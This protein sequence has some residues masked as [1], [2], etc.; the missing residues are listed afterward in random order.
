MYSPLR[1]DRDQCVTFDRQKAGQRRKHW[2]LSIHIF[3]CDLEL[4]LLRLH[5]TIPVLHAACLIY[6]SDLTGCPT[7]KDLLNNDKLGRPADASRTVSRGCIL[8]LELQSFGQHSHLLVT[9][10]VMS[11]LNQASLQHQTAMI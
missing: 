8:Q 9:V 6:L 2:H 7:S 1:P 11:S 3:L 4:V 5:N 10:T